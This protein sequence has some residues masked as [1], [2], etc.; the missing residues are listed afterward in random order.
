[1]KR[2]RANLLR[3]INTIATNLEFIADF[4]VNVVWTWR[5]FAIWECS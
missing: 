1:M 2:R 5:P 3:S 4:A